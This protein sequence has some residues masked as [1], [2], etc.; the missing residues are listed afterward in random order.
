MT[1]HDTVTLRYTLSCHIGIVWC[2]VTPWHQLTPLTW[3][4]NVTSHEIIMSRRAHTKCHAFRFLECIQHIYKKSFF[5]CK[6]IFLHHSMFLND[7]SSSCGS[8]ETL[9]LSQLYTAPHSQWKHSN[10]LAFYSDRALTSSKIYRLVRCPWTSAFH[11]TSGFKSKIKTEEMGKHSLS[12]FFRLL[13]SA[14]IAHKNL[15]Y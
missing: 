6:T 2:Q 13:T 9:V 10:A 11:H 12:S 8:F 14:L 3:H 15:T 1:S 7:M 4:Y 5:Q